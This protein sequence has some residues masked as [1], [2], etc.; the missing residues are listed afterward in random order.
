MIKI[1]GTILPW[2]TREYDPYENLALAVLEQNI[3]DV[4]RLKAL[5]THKVSPQRT[6][7]IVNY[8]LNA[9]NAFHSG[10]FD[11]WF[12]VLNVDKTRPIEKM[13]SLSGSASKTILENQ[14]KIKREKNEYKT[15]NSHGS[16]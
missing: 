4:L 5:Y 2:E 7:E 3:E 8:G 13:L 16:K 10:Y 12:N 6:R 15:R 14:A 1:I 9:L 11:V